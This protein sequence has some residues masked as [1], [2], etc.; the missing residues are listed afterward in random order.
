[1]E[2]LAKGAPNFISGGGGLGCLD[3]ALKPIQFLLARTRFLLAYVA[4][5]S[6][7]DLHFDEVTIGLRNEL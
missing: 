4:F 5:S 2:N 6:H 7:D 3:P 1:V